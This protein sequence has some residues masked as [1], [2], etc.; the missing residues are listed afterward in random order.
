MAKNVVINTNVSRVFHIQKAKQKKIDFL[1]CGIFF[2]VSASSRK[3]K[4]KLFQRTLITR[5]FL[6]A[7]VEKVA[8]YVVAAREKERQTQKVVFATRQEYI[9]RPVRRAKRR[10]SLPLKS[11]RTR[12]KKTICLSWFG[13][14]VT[15]HLL[16][17]FV[18]GREKYAG[19]FF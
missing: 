18:F 7:A 3:G 15:T 14:T 19:S 4:K 5:M 13:R 12:E 2:A 1:F 9:G 16:C 17:I 11:W 6:P 8:I 10:A